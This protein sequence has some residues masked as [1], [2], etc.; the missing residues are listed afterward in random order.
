MEHYY[1]YFLKIPLNI[2]KDFATDYYG[3]LRYQITLHR[4]LQQF[5]E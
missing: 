4:V 2:R 1:P 5:S 3:L